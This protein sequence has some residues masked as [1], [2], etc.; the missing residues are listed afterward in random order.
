MKCMKY[1]SNTKPIPHQIQNQYHI[2]DRDKTQRS[3]K[4]EDRIMMIRVSGKG[5]PSTSIKRIGVRGPIGP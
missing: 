3:E 2:K 1:I 4:W 5:C